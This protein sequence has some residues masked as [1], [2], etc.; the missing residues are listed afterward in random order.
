MRSNEIKYKGEGIWGLL[1]TV[2]KRKWRRTKEEG[3]GDG[4][5]LASRWEHDMMLL[6]ETCI[7]TGI[8]CIR[9]RLI[10]GK[11]TSPHT[12]KKDGGRAPYSRKTSMQ[13]YRAINRY[14][15]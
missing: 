2:E 8:N 13:Q 6:L 9:E 15:G 5:G 3:R 12:Q 7:T 14:C 1:Y 4:R 11:C 10:N